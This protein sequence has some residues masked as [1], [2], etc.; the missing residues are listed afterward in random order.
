MYKVA[1]CDDERNICSELETMLLDLQVELQEKFQIDIYYSGETL[2]QSLTGKGVY[3]IVFLD[4]ELMKLSGIGVG[5][6][7]RDHMKDYQTQ[8]VYISSKQGYSMQLFQTQPLDFLLK[9][10]AKDKV[11]T[12]LKKMMMV[13]GTPG[14]LFCFRKGQDIYRIPYEDILYFSSDA[15]LI[16][17]FRMQDSLSYYDKLSNII[18]ELPSYFLPIRKSCI[19]NKNHVEKYTYKEVKMRN[20][21]TLV[22][23]RDYWKSVR[24]AHISA[25]REQET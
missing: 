24:E 5:C 16:H 18:A 4:I 10:I 3:D 25:W 19:I 13:L 21:T 17:I 22:I 20:D 12:V 14:R 23:S 6:Y 8:I 9:P 15:H 1:I 2:R 7:I 11:L